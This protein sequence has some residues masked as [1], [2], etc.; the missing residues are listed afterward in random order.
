LK[1]VQKA[2]SRREQTIFFPSAIDPMSGAAE[3][4]LADGFLSQKSF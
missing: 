2:Y 3:A 4:I 1:D